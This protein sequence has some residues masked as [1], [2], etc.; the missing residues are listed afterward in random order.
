MWNFTASCS[1]HLRTAETPDR[2]KDGDQSI[3]RGEVRV[4]ASPPIR[5]K[6]QIGP[7]FQN[8]SVQQSELGQYQTTS[9]SQLIVGLA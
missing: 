4:C 8:L 1:Q 9:E 6:E 3:E 2:Q 7:N 5:A